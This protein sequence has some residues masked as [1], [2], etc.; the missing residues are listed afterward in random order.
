MITKEKKNL[1]K[2][3][4]EDGSTLNK[5]A[6]PLVINSFKMHLDGPMRKK[7]AILIVLIFSSAI[8]DVF[9][10]ASILPLIKLATDTSVIHSNEY[11]SSVYNYLQFDSEKSFLLF[12]ILSVLGFFIVKSVYGIFVNYLETRFTATLAY[13]ITRKQFNKYFNLEFHQFAGMKSSVITHHIL[14]NPLSYVTWV[15]M[16]TIMLISEFS[17]LFLVVG[18]IAWYDIKLFLFIAIII[19]PS[20]WLIYALLRSRVS[21][22]GEEMNRLFPLSL[23]SLSQTIGGYADIKLANKE[24][25]YRDEF[26][27]TQKRY[28]QLNMASHLP[29]LIPLRAN[30]LVALLGVV[31]IFI[32]AIFLTD[33]SEKAIVMISLFAAAA[34]RL[35]PSL[36]RIIS[37]FMYIRKNMTALQNISIYPELAHEIISNADDRKMS[38]EKSIEIRN[39]YFRFP[40]ENTDMLKDISMTISRGEKI[41]IVGVSGSGKTTLMNILLRFYQEQKGGIYIDDI[42][43]DAENMQSWRNLLG[44]V[45]QDIFLMDA[46]IRDNITFGDTNPDQKLLNQAIKQASLEELI[47]SLPEG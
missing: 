16:P 35:M 22:I 19:G 47:Q 11:L 34:Y 32:Y 1:G 30:E 41:G 3:E 36:N 45:K 7:A 17:I 18:G 20:T 43:V 23:G 2:K 39:L 27:K 5:D 6:F 24:A 44:Y 13:K 26:L 12:M 21:R 15:V 42:K 14:N 8:L 9:G 25:H 37:S 10:I 33:N 38:F 40:K 29:N 28:H 46:S 4:R 31:L